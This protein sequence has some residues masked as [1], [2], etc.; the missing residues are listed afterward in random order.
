MFN[1]QKVTVSSTCC[2]HTIIY[3]ITCFFRTL[4]ACDN[5]HRS[6]LGK[7]LPSLL[8]IANSSVSTIPP[9]L[10]PLAYTEDA[11][12]SGRKLVVSAFDTSGHWHDLF[13][14]L[15][16]VARNEFVEKNPSEGSDG[17]CID[18]RDVSDSDS[19]EKK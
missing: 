6:K 16:A 12:A 7:N 9:S 15:S 10:S 14:R 18:C 11:V 3:T 4:I 1:L 17:G 2:I 5:S 19:R 8:L 13:E